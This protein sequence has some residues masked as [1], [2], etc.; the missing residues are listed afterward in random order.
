M[1]AT[2]ET[3]PARRVNGDAPATGEPTR[4]LIYAKIP[5]VMAEVGAVGKGRKNQQQGYSFRGIDDVYAAV[6]GP[7]AAAGVFVVPEVLDRDRQERETKNGGVLMYTILTVRHTFYAED[8]SS[9]SCVTVGEA[10][11]SGDKSCNKAMSAAMKYALLEVFCIPTEEPKDTENDT[12]RVRP[13]R[14][15]E[16][17]DHN[18]GEVVPLATAEQVREIQKLL[19]LANLPDGVV[20]KWF[21]KAGVEEWSQ[22]SARALA[23]CIDFARGRA[24][25]REA[26]NTGNGASPNAPA[27]GDGTPGATPPPAPAPSQPAAPGLAE[28]MAYEQELTDVLSGENWK[29]LI[30]DA[31]P[32]EWAKGDAAKAIEA[33]LKLLGRAPG[34]AAKRALYDAMR[35]GR[36]T[37]GGVMQN[38]AK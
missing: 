1:N 22:M 14:R 27:K 5:L 20:A 12:H 9:V 7:L 10:M 15:P 30:M 36:V 13:A 29:R 26:A 3:L 34:L 8:G 21:A 25:P 4:G 32:V 37:L 33:W 18:T 31:A 28:N 16:A 38:K 23:S 35:E 17:V 6:Q 19:P 2:P 11:D 24:V